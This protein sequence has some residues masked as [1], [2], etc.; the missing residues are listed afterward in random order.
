MSFTHCLY[1][2]GNVFCESFFIYVVTCF[3]GCCC[4]VAISLLMRSECLLHVIVVTWLP[5]CYYAV[6]IHSPMNPL[7]WFSPLSLPAEFLSC[8]GPS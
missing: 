3:P 7:H 4:A 8:S 2:V 6:T 1:E 5:G